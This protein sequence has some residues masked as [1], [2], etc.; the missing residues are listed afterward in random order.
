MPELG[1]EW[2]LIAMIT[3]NTLFNVLRYFTNNKSN[4]KKQQKLCT[5]ED[6]KREN[7]G[8]I[9]SYNLGDD[10]ISQ[11]NLKWLRRYDHRF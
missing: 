4:N 7:L 9:K 1:W 11:N 8:E 3:I 10:Y 6:N 5:C 2:W